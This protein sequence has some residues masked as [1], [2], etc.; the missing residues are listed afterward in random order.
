MF[1]QWSMPSDTYVLSSPLSHL[2]HQWFVLAMYITGFCDSEFLVTETDRRH[3]CH[4][5]VL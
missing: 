4:C 5:S 1:V 2:L 3:C